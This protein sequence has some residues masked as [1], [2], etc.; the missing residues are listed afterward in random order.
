MRT[1]FQ[2]GLFMLLWVTMACTQAKESLPSEEAATKNPIPTYT[3]EELAKMS[4]AT[5]AGGCFWCVEA[6]FERI[7]GVKEVVSGY[8]GGTRPNPT[9]KQVSAGSTNYAEAVRVYYDPEVISFEELLEIFFVAHD[10][11][12]LN[13]QGP[14]IGRQYRSAIFYHDQAQ[15]EASEKYIAKLNES[16]KFS[17]PIVTEVTELKNFYKAEGYHQDYYELNPNQP[18]VRSVSR[19]KVEKVMKVFADKLKKEYQ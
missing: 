16:G 17:Q 9:Y 18:Y 2:S 14:D 19:P 13:R 3:S 1:L 11:T 10:P 4:K 12:Q 8:S 6:A 7:E 15:K 5:F